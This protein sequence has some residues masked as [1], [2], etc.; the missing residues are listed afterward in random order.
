MK[1]DDIIVITDELIVRYLAGEANPDEAIALH[2]WMA[3]SDNKTYFENFQSAWQNS[4]PAKKS[5]LPDVELGWKNI[6]SQFHIESTGVHTEKI[7]KI[8]RRYDY[9]LKIAAA[10]IIILMI[11]VFTYTYFQRN[12]VIPK[13]SV[14]TK[15]A[16]HKIILPDNSRV[17][18]SRFS[19]VAYTKNFYGSSREIHLSGEAFFEVVHNLN[20]PFIVHTKLADIKV[21]GTAFNVTLQHDTAEVSVARGKVLVYTD[22]DSVYLE[23]G[24]SARIAS[25]S[26]FIQDV[27][28]ADANM[29][30]YA[31]RKFEFKNTRLRDVFKCIEKSYPYS[32]E[33]RNEAIKNCKLTATFENKSAEY[34]VTLIA[35]TL[36]LTLTKKNHVFVLEGKGCL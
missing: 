3:F 22:R 24:Q 31:T 28:L 15:D 12:N 10:I 9:L 7:K 20:K 4:Y 32:I 27:T 26:K 30:G 33:V 34:I 16:I 29:W 6:E 11:G 5:R 8:P 14:L 17:I 18:M 36:D 21:V 19:A 1:N 35:E 25:D 13:I 2:D 23:P